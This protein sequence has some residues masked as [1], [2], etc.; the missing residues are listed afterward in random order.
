MIH[1]DETNGRTVVG[2]VLICGEERTKS[3]ISHIDDEDK[4]GITTKDIKQSLT[5]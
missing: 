5:M 1:I 3:V 4:A 2:N